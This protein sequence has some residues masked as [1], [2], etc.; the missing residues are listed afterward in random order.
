M[1]I[2]GAYPC[3]FYF[4]PLN[5]ICTTTTSTTTT[6]TV[7]LFPI[8][9]CNAGTFEANG[10][11]CQTSVLNGK[12]LYTKDNFVLF[13]YVRTGF[14]AWVI[15]NNDGFVYLYFSNEDVITP[16]LVM[17]WNIGLMIGTFFTE[18]CVGDLPTPTVNNI[19]C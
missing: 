9:V 16:D 4:L 2:I 13:W 15:R 5:P 14:S 12:P 8:W 17:D 7:C 19:D 18:N 10:R 1:G 3:E 11:Y 6:A